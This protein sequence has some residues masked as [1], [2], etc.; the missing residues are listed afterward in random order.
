MFAIFL[1]DDLEMFAEAQQGRML[2][3]FFVDGDPLE[4]LVVCDEVVVGKPA[5]GE[6]ELLYRQVLEYGNPP[7]SNLTGS[8]PPM[9]DYLW[10]N[11]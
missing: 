2:R 11:Q 10:L 1:N 9:H 3:F 4:L 7:N 5:A 6:V 8:L